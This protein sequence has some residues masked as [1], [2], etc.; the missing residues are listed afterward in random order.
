MTG[1]DQKN[2]SKIIIENLEKIHR[3]EMQNLQLRHQETERAISNGYKAQLDERDNI[4]QCMQNKI[5]ETENELSRY[6]YFVQE[7]EP[8][9]REI[10]QHLKQNQ[11]DFL[12]Q[13][14]I[15]ITMGEN[16]QLQIQELMKEVQ[17]FKKSQDQINIE[18]DK[19]RVQNKMYKEQL[20]K[21]ELIIYGPDGCVDKPQ[22]KKKS[23]SRVRLRN[24]SVLQYVWT[25]IQ[26]KLQIRRKRIWNH[27]WIKKSFIS[28]NLQLNVPKTTSASHY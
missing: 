24:K 25:L 3:K 2:Y 9:L 13:N 23:N 10:H 21:Y 11:Q 18:L 28:V 16:Q 7:K 12:T 14:Q 26:N 6:K 15:A 20:Q 1:L 5:V 27:E 22:K 17:K 19:C 4:I 8:L